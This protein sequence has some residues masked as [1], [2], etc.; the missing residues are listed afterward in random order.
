MK[1]SYQ[2]LSNTSSY[3][4]P[5]GNFLTLGSNWRWLWPLKSILP[6][7]NLHLLE[8][9]KVLKGGF[10]KVGQIRPPQPAYR[11]KHNKSQILHRSVHRYLQRDVF[12][13]PAF[14][15]QKLNKL[16]NKAIAPCDHSSPC[17][18]TRSLVLLLRINLN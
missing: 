12:I 10:E 1:F 16:V 7:T 8:H 3:T 4:Y 5:S 13:Y 11:P 6:E 15:R 18:Q 14:L 9:W 17:T 2:G